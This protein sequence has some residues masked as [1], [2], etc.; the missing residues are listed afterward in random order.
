MMAVSILDARVPM[1]AL[2][3]WKKRMAGWLTAQRGKLALF[4]GSLDLVDAATAVAD[5][6]AD[7]TAELREGELR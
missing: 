5:A 6:M 4:V 2:F 3:H 7:I 1:T